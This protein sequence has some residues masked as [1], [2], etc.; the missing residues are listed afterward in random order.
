MGLGS[1]QDY[2][3][4]VSLQFRPSSVMDLQLHPAEVLSKGEAL[5]TPE[6]PKPQGEDGAS[7]YWVAVKELI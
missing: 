3:E 4:V 7:P 2:D 5:G 6:S 1:P